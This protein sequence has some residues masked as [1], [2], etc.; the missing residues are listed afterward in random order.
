MVFFPFFFSFLLLE[1][2][3]DAKRKHLK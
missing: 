3:K 2:K 1:K